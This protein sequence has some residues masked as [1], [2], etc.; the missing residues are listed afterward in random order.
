[1]GVQMYRELITFCLSSY[2]SSEVR[3]RKPQKYVVRYLQCKTFIDSG[4]LCIILLLFY[5]MW[6]FTWN[7]ANYLV[8]K[9]SP[10]QKL[11]LLH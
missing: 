5:C 9:K 8:K 2:F 1:M 10:N 6:H 4:K 7:Y 11:V 3:E